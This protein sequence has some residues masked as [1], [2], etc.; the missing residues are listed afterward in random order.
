MTWDLDVCEVGGIWRLMGEI[1]KNNMLWDK[2]LLFASRKK[3]EVI[4][5]YENLYSYM[6]SLERGDG[7]HINPHK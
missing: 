6:M 2:T 7:S 4:V 1:Y 5:L 3:M